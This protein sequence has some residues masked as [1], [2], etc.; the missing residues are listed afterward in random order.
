M[1]KKI[2][3]DVLT[4][5]RIA[6][7]WTG[8]YMTAMPF[9]LADFKVGAVLPTVFYMFRWG[10]RRGRGAFKSTF[11]PGD[12]R[13]PTVDSVVDGLAA[14]TDIR[15]AET[16]LSR[17]VLGDL[18][19]AYCVENRRRAEGRG[20]QVQRVFPTHYMSSWIDLPDTVAD[21][22]RVPEM[23]LAT[24]VN[25]DDGDELIT[26]GGNRRLPLHCAIQDNELLALFGAGMSVRPELGI[27]GDVFD[28]EAPVGLDQLLTIRLAQ[29]CGEAPGRA[30]GK[31]E[32]GV[33]ANQRPVATVATRLFREDFRVFVRAYGKSIPRLSLLPMMESCIAIGLTTT[34]LASGAMLEA[35]SR[36]GRLPDVTTQTPWPLFVDCSLAMDRD[37]Q[38]AAEQSMDNCR[39]RLES[40]PTTLMCLRLLDYEAKHNE[41]I[42]KSGLPRRH[43]VATDWLNLLGTL[44]DGSHEESWPMMKYFFSPKCRELAEALSQEDPS[45]P[46]IDILLSDAAQRLPVW[47]LAEALTHLYGRRALR[48]DLFEFFNACLMVNE[49]NG[50]ARSRRVTRRQRE[51]RRT[52]EMYSIVLSNTAIEYLVHRHLRRSGKGCKAAR[53]SLPAFLQLLRERYGLFI[54]R[55]PA[56]LAVPND[57]L[58]RNRMFFERRL[59]DL[60]LLVGVNDAESMKRLRQRFDA[61]GDGDGD[62]DGNE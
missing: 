62:G 3:S 42:V 19:L 44:A 22:R 39:R 35:W 10:H 9:I 37:L 17:S 56:D 33:I 58:L 4:N 34:F 8:S 60:G 7:V 48:G 45:H 43:P 18:L 57:L 61:S 59:R 28:E 14:L 13:R 46:A 23:L 25:Q 11:S 31:G 36:D 47:R 41:S 24:L 32:P 50:L 21:L 40:L 26:T 1:S 15:G 12:G 6:S 30:T 52:S 51:G 29:K 53:L 38:H 49:P 55:A 54:D 20:E 2:A 16:T 5:A 27:R